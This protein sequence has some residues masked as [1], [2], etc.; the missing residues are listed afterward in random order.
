MISVATLECFTHGK[1]GIKIHKMACGYKELQNDF[2]YDII[3]GNVLVTASMFLP[4]KESIESL[5]NMKLPKSDHEFK[6]SKA[7]NEEND[8]KV[9]EYISKALKEK[10][11]CNIAISTTAGVG[12][13]AISILTDKN[14]YL[15]TSDI[16]GNLI[17]G[18]NI[19]KRQE[20]AVNKAF[21]AFIKILN[22][23][24]N[25]KE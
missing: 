22:E 21:E 9:A 6:Y 2:G 12:K 16:Y 24:Y 25:I 18:E 13:G 23:E 7:Y 8:L 1:I 5:L 19:L 10:L 11:K 15:F 20:N 17:K 3:R 14:S 4:S